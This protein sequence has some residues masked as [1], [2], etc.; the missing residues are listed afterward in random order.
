[1]QL[2]SHLVLIIGLTNRFTAT[3][4]ELLSLKSSIGLFFQW[5]KS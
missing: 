3:E 2:N 1:M 4:S 5:R